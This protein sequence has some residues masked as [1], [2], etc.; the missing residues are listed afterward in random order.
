MQAP[1]SNG[2]PVEQKLIRLYMDLTGDSEPAARA[3]YMYVCCP[4]RG[5]EGTSADT[6][7]QSSLKGLASLRK[8]DS[9]SRALPSGAGAA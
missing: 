3:V 8:T 7:T 4:V 2:K 1:H 5:N 9:V 6:P